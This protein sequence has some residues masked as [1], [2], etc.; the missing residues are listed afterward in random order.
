[1]ESEP[2]CFG[3]LVAREV[4]GPGEAVDDADLVSLYGERQGRLVS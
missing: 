3:A 4:R 1:L 2:R